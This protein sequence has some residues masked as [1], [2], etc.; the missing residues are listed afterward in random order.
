MMARTVVVTIDV[1]RCPANSFRDFSSGHATDLE[2]EQWRRVGGKA[3]LK[4]LER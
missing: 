1:D 3:W 4:P 2:D